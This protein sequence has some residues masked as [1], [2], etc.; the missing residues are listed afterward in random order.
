M[1]RGIIEK[2]EVFSRL[3][4][5]SAAYRRLFCLAKSKKNI[6]KVF[7]N[8]DSSPIIGRARFLLL[9]LRLFVI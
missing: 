1:C 3:S 6:R 4:N 2:I 5:D 7:K 8:A 9:R